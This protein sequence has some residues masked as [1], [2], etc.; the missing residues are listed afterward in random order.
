[1]IV[2]VLMGRGGPRAL[3][4][5]LADVS[6][7]SL[8]AGRAEPPIAFLNLSLILSNGFGRGG[9]GILATDV[10]PFG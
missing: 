6:G 10:V 8:G 4:D 9:G 1:V 7:L 5:C 3:E 2:D